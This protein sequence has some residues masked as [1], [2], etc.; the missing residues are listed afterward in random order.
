MLSARTATPKRAAP[1]PTST[2]PSI[3][4]PPPLPLAR[5]ASLA[6]RARLGYGTR[7]GYEPQGPCMTSGVHSIARPAPG[8]ATVYALRPHPQETLHV[9]VSGGGYLHPS[10]EV[11]DPV[12]WHL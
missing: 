4:R 9:F 1:L 12:H 5:L 6:G 10:V 2:Q 7:L 11:L 3:M 8:E